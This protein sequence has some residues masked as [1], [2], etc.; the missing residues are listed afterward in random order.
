MLVD[1]RGPE[2][3]VCVCVCVC[4][5]ACLSERPLGPL[6]SPGGVG[7]PGLLKLRWGELG[8]LSSDCVGTGIGG[9]QASQQVPSFTQ[10]KAA[11]E[12]AAPC[13]SACLRAEA[14]PWL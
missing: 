13:L 9:R 5:C 4:V 14:A 12:G 2:E 6:P 10:R 11:A 1:I 3:C 8:N 7:L